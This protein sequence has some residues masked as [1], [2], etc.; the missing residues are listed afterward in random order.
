MQYHL[1][2]F[3][4][5]A[6]AFGHSWKIFAKTDIKE[7]FSICFVYL[8]TLSSQLI[9]HL[10]LTFMCGVIQHLI[11]FFFLKV[12]LKSQLVNIQCNISFRCTI[13][14]FNTSIQHPVLITSSSLLNPHPLLTHLSIPLP[15]CNHSLFSIVK[16]LFLGCLISLFFH[17]LL[18]FV[19]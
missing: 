5:V 16:T 7:L 8:L 12:L 4:I 6:C 2:I 15:S 13:K 14:W 11:S 10:G 18:C 17:L 3:A 1:L 19:S 9:I